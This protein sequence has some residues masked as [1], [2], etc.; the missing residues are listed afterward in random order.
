MT[1]YNMKEQIKITAFYNSIEKFII[2]TKRN[3]Q[4]LNNFKK[5]RIQMPLPHHHIHTLS[6]FK[7]QMF[8]PNTRSYAHFVYLTSF[9]KVIYRSLYM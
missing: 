6:T 1:N 2:L 3:Y 8:F 7:I 5:F 9:C 4:W